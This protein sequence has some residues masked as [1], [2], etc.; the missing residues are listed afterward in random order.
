MAGV[1]WPAIYQSQEADNLAELMVSLAHRAQVFEH[2]L[3]DFIVSETLIEEN[4]DSKGKLQEHNETLSRL[5]GKQLR[6]KLTDG[7]IE[8]G[9]EESRQIESINGKSQTDK[10]IKPKGTQVGGTFTSILLSH[11]APRDQQ[12]Y[13]FEL[14]TERPL[15]GEHKTYLINFL[16]RLDENEQYYIF[17]GQ[18]YH[19]QQRGRAWIDI[20]TLLPLRIE[21]NETNLPKG[22]ESIFYRV[23]YAPI[24]LDAEI[25]P[26]PV[27]SLN[28]VKEEHG[29]NR[30]ESRYSN[31]RKFATDVKLD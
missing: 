4:F 20:E 24:K 29:I 25:Y 26:L 17:D 5:T 12:D 28:E 6:T 2:A 16:S 23:D 9:F 13:L 8:L 21:F 19:S 18:R 31:Y 11:F 1:V 30:V 10:Q 22:I 27:V 3:P 7:T 14:A 15:I